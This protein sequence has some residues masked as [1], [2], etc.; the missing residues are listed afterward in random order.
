MFKKSCI[1][2]YCYLIINLE[3]HISLT[4]HFN[5]SIRY[6]TEQTTLFLLSNTFIAVSVTNSDLA[7]DSWSAKLVGAT[8]TPTSL[9]TIAGNGINDHCEMLPRGCLLMT[10]NRTQLRM[11]LSLPRQR[12][13]SNCC[14]AVHSYTSYIQYFWRCVL[15]PCNIKYLCVTIL[16]MYIVDSTVA[17]LNWWVQ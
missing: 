9:G 16:M 8:I 13:P 12:L 11:D 7:R 1:S 15:Q 3:I 14:F 6:H 4:N 2:S 10:P 17:A 5:V